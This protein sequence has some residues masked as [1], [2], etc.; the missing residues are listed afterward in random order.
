MTIQKLTSATP[1]ATR[2]VISAALP[3]VLALGACGVTTEPE[4]SSREAAPE[5]AAQQESTIDRPV[6][7]CRPSLG[8]AQPICADFTHKASCDAMCL[9]TY[10]KTCVGSDTCEGN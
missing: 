8:A 6:F 7:I 4:G 5:A 1:W 3:L 9:S 10:G 2:L